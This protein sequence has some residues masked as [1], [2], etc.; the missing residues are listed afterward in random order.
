MT[1]KIIACFGEVLAQLQKV[2]T[3]TAYF[4]LADACKACREA[5]AIQVSDHDPMLKLLALTPQQLGI[6]QRILA[7]HIDGKFG[8]SLSFREFQCYKS[9]SKSI[10]QLTTT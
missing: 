7:H 3:E 6:L 8:D 4:D 10:F 2:G 5:L 1:K 9:L